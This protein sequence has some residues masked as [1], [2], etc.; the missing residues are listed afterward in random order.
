MVFSQ[1]RSLGSDRSHPLW[2]LARL[3]SGPLCAHYGRS[4][5][6]GC[7]LEADIPEATLSDRDGWIPDI[8]ER[9]LPAS[10]PISARL[11][12]VLLPSNMDDIRH[13]PGQ[14]EAGR[15]DA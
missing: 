8:P 10:L 14:H 11:L 12:H 7:T 1:I 13:G 5:R 4:H 9:S 6:R 2:M 3:L 15:A